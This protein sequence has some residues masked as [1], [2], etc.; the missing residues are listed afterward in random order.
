MM[1]IDGESQVCQY[2]SLTKKKVKSWLE[3]AKMNVLIIN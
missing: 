3:F 2:V 1:E